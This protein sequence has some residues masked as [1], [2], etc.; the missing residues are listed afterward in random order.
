MVWVCA[1]RE[2]RIGVSWIPHGLGLRWKDAGSAI[3]GNSAVD[4]ADE[5]E[6]KEDPCQVRDG[7]GGE[8]L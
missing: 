4:V 5:H 2:V 8:V 3:T 1:G 7:T 6:G